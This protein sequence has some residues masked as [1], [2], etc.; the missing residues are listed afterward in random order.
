M[1]VLQWQWLRQEQ[2]EVHPQRFL[3]PRSS[4]SITAGACPSRE[5]ASAHPSAPSAM[6]LGVQAAGDC[7]VPPSPPPLTPV[8]QPKLADQYVWTGQVRER[9]EEEERRQKED[10]EC[11]HHATLPPPQQATLSAYQAASSWARP[12]PV[13]IDLTGGDDDKCKADD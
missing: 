12:P 3:L 5:A 4:S 9:E 1:G 13:F 11:A 7:I 6:A 8:T 2:G 10:E